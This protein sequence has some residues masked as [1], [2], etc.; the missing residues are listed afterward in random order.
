MK[1]FFAIATT[2]FLGAA[3]FMASAETV[4]LINPLGETDPRVLAGRLISGIISVIGTITLLM[5]VYA[6]VLWITAQ[7]ETKKV[8]RGKH[9]MLWCVLGLTMIAGAYVLV[10]VL[11]KVFT[12]GRAY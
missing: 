4:Y 7:G 6:G 9:I 10:N 2:I 3:P 11:I 8:E 5:F 12:T 1:K